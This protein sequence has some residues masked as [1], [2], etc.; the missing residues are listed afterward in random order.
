[1][2]INVKF[3]RCPV[4]GGKDQDYPASSLTSADAQD[5]LDTTGDGLYL[6]SY[7]GQL[8][9]NVCK[10]RLQNDEQSIVMADKHAEAEQ[11]RSKHGFRKTIS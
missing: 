11:F 9:C 7:K 1:M 10:H 4:C 5:N 3:G 8:M 6:E 2:N